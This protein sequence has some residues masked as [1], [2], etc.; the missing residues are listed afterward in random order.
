MIHR[1]KELRPLIEALEADD[2]PVRCFGQEHAFTGG[3]RFQV[4]AFPFEC[5]RAVDS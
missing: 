4:F 1:M 5:E 3:Q 2:L